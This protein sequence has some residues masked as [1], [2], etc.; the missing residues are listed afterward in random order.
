MAGRTRPQ[1]WVE[2]YLHS[3]YI[4]SRLY[5]YITTFN[6]TTR[7]WRACQD[8]TFHI[9]NK[10]VD[11]F[12]ALCLLTCPHTTF[13]AF[14]IECLR[15]FGRYNGSEPKWRDSLNTWPRMPRHRRDTSN[16]F[17]NPRCFLDISNHWMENLWTASS[18]HCLYLANELSTQF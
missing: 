2:V 6:F 3:P 13:V 17:G 16:K 11:R 8:T 4:P 18:N 15:K 5:I 10:R 7:L 14:R 12:T 1:E 9:R